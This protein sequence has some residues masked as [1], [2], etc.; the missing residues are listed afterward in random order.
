[1]KR[2]SGIGINHFALDFARISE[3]CLE[4]IETILPES[5]EQFEKI[6]HDPDADKQTFKTAVGTTVMRN[7]PS[8]KYILKNFNKF[9]E[10]AKK[11]GATVS[12]C[13]SFGFDEF[14]KDADEV[15]YRCMGIK[16]K[17]DN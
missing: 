1:M 4:K 11:Y 3:A 12:A 7:A 8:K 10:I 15:G 9:K 2:F 17:K 14:N 5:K 16:I 13:N 6:Y